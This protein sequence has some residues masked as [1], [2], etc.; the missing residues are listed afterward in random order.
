MNITIELLQEQIRAYGYKL[1]T[2]GQLIS[3]KPRCTG[4]YASVRRGRMYMRF[5]DETLLWSGT[6]A[7]EFLQKYWY[8]KPT[9]S[10]SQIPRRAHTASHS[11][12][13]PENEASKHGAAIHARTVQGNLFF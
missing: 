9:V 13:A 10:A 11:A 1:D 8:E 12:P 7:G 4:V 3:P 6:D 2:R 5:A